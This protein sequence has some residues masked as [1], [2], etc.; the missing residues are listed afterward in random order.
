MKTEGATAQI[1][2]VTQP[3]ATAWSWRFKTEEELINEYGDDWKEEVNWS[4]SN[5]M[6]YLLGEEIAETLNSRDAISLLQKQKGVNYDAINTFLELGI[7][8]GVD[9]DWVFFSFRDDFSK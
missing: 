4:S 6:D 8:S 7:S 9:D 5:G 1:T 2:P 3:T